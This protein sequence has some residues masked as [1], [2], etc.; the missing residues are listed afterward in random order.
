MMVR[1]SVPSPSGRKVAHL[2]GFNLFTWIF[3]SS[4][5]QVRLQGGGGPG[6][7]ASDSS[8]VTG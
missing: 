5:A 6:I 7:F 8:K 1:G 3:A 4:E 2:L